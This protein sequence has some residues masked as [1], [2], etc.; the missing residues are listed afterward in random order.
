[1]LAILILGAE[2]VYAAV[3]G[4]TVGSTTVDADTI[5]EAGTGIILIA[6]DVLD[7]ITIS[8]DQ[9]YFSYPEGCLEG[10]YIKR[11]NLVFSCASPVSS[12]TVGDGQMRGNLTI[13]ATGGLSVSNNT[14]TNVLVDLVSVAW[15][16]LTSIPTGCSTNEF[17]QAVS[18]SSFTCA[19]LTSLAWS[20]LTGFPAGCSSPTWVRTI[21]T[22]L[23]CVQPSYS[24]LSGT[25]QPTYSNI[26]S[27]PAACADGQFVSQV[28]NP[29]V[30][31]TPA[32]GG[33]GLTPTVLA[34]DQESLS[35]ST[36]T[37]IFTIP[38]TTSKVNVIYAILSQSTSGTAVGIQSR[39]RVTQSAHT[40]FCNFV[41]QS[42][43]TANANIDNIAVT[44][45]PAD[46]AQTTE[47]ST[48]MA[49]T[50]VTCTINVNGT[51]GDLVLEFQSETGASVKTHAGSYYTKVTT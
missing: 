43:A 9:A 28:A 45:N 40:G 7:K 46:T 37:T 33:G 39:A 22:T 5:F 8:I 14:N 19:T 49:P 21:G 26:Q 42:S 27:F 2:S 3:N 17:I 36:Y 38:L 32:G 51:A 29:P 11:L 35:S 6:D 1:M 31:G 4:I 30:C 24:D 50:T 18:S 10:E 12:L 47:F 16:K 25:N 23:T 13:S 41:R 34:S 15:S 44:T 20:A 48:I